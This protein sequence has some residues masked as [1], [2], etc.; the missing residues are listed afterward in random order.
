MKKPSWTAVCV[1]TVTALIG[2]TMLYTGMQ[3]QTTQPV[4]I[5]QVVRQ[6]ESAATEITVVTETVF[7]ETTPPFTA[8]TAA[9]TTASTTELSALTTERTPDTNLNTAEPADL[10]SVPGIGAVLAEAIVAYRS[11]IGGFTRR[12]Q[13][14]EVSGIG[15]VLAARIMEQFVIPGELPPETETQPTQTAPPQTE[16]QPPETEPPQTAEITTVPPEPDIPPEG[17]DAN[18]V[19]KEQLLR[20]PDMTEEMADDILE[21][22]G[23]LGGRFNS[24]YEVSIP[25]SVSDIYFTHVIKKYLYVENDPAF[26]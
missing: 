24:V 8:E 1:T 22:R 10:E 25:D 15:E 13:L 3:M 11:Q 23:K 17:F 20:I 9:E 21:V 12:S 2:V 4:V 5:R 14:R 18:T 6:E 16:T 19:T 7:T 26:E